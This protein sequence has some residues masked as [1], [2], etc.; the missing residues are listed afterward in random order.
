ML[1]LEQWQWMAIALI[2]VTLAGT[3]RSSVLMWVSIAATVL[4][5]VTWYDHTIPVMPQIMI[6]G[7]ITLAGIVITDFFIKPRSH[8]EEHEENNAVIQAADPSEIIDRTFVLSEPIVHGVGKIEIN[9]TVWRL[10]GEDAGA[11][12]SIR[13]LAVDGIERD[14]LIVARSED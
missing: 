8:V 5:G 13:V 14:L 10:R 9:G 12:D 4:S 6:F 3:L 11:G 7:L 2:A 1:I